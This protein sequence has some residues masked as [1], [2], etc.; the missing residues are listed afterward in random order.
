MA[1]V[2]L[3]RDGHERLHRNLHS[4][5][6]YFYPRISRV[7]GVLSLADSWDQTDNQLDDVLVQ[8]ERWQAV[9]RQR[10]P[11]TAFV[12]GQQAKWIERGWPQLDLPSSVELGH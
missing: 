1:I 7:L 12:L 3:D 8:L 9:C 6:N 4:Q 2:R 10:D 11:A 5:E